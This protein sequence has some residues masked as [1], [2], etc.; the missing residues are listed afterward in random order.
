M[1]KTIDRQTLEA[2]LTSRTK[3]EI[4]KQYGITAKSVTRLI[5]QYGLPNPPYIQS[6]ETKRLRAEALKAT[7]QRDPDLIERKVKGFRA[8]NQKVKGKRWEEL[9]STEKVGALKEQA[10]QRMLGKVLRKP[11]EGPKFCVLCGAEIEKGKSRKTQSYCK[12]CMS[13]YFKSYYGQRKEHY[14]KISNENRRRRQSDWRKVLEQLKSKPCTDCGKI[15]PP[16]CLDFDHLERE[17]KVAAIPVM[18]SGNASRERILAELEKTEVVC[19]NCHREREH[20]RYLLLGK[21][22][23][24]LSPRQRKNK[25][26]IEQAKNRPCVDCGE[27]FSLWQMDFDHVRGEKISGVGYLAMSAATEILIAEIEKCEVVCAVCHRKRTF[28]NK[29]KSFNDRRL[30]GL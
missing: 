29:N 11:K 14:L 12:A 7:H 22:P 1:P 25:E 24:H 28:A 10:R 8:H 18:I 30:Y 9:Y 26:L 19:A 27:C 20:Q 4:A 16:F 21:T 23:V 3:Y 6:E 15:F 17:N 5:H 13:S 2:L